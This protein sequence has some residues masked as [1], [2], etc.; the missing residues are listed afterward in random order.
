M[1]ISHYFSAVDFSKLTKKSEPGYRYCLGAQIEKFST[2]FTR[3]NLHK[4]GIAIVGVPSYNGEWQSAQN[5]TPDLIRKELYKLA[6]F[7]KKINIVDFGNLKQSGSLKS[8]YLALRDIVEYLN[9]CNIV[10]IVLG[11]TQ[12]LSI[13]I[14]NAFRNENFFSFAT[15]DAELDVKKGIERINHKN[16][17][18]KLFK[19]V[20]DLFQFSLLA[21]QSHF[22]HDSL[23]DKTKGIN[24]PL[25]LGKLR[26]RLSDAEP[27]LRNSH[28]LSFDFN[29]IKQIERGGSGSMFPN[30]LHSEE[31]CQIAWYA[32]LSE[33]VKVFGLF[34]VPP[35][36]KENNLSTFLAAQILW[37]FVEGYLNSPNEI[38]AKS[39]YFTTYKVE[40]KGIEKPIVFLKSLKTKR[41]WMEINSIKNKKYYFACSEDDYRQASN[42]E[43]PVLWLQYVQKTDKILK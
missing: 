2:G 21:Y 4:A 32:G 5:N 35:Q 15:V 9:E 13:G 24:I 11:G 19:D 36:S 29:S 14:S 17:L 8:T 16:Y 34:E 42:N 18:T 25:R 3:G 38:P 26:E 31:A 10:T 40:V 27:I 43:I 12:D 39:D 1:D 30:G 6:G 41:W 28:V 23:F 7:S 20:P 22:I 37:Y 33:K